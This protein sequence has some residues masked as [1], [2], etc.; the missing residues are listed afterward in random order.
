MTKRTHESTFSD[1]SLSV[2]SRETRGQR[3][4]KQKNEKKKYTDPFKCW[5]D[6]DFPQNHVTFKQ[7]RNC[8]ESGNPHS[9]GGSCYDFDEF[10]G[11]MTH[12]T[13][14][15]KALQKPY[16]EINTPESDV[17]YATFY[18]QH[19]FANIDILKKK[20]TESEKRILKR[21]N[22]NKVR[23]LKDILKEKEKKKRKEKRK[24]VRLPPKFSEWPN[25]FEYINEKD[26]TSTRNKKRKVLRECL[27]RRIDFMNDCVYDCGDISQ[28]WINAHLDFIIILQILA[29]QNNA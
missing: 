28:T 19:V 24:Q 27:N 8:P 7:E 1:N 9:V 29:A 5:N 12:P 14:R 6:T 11:E 16:Y 22:I 4:K 2:H 21:A 10:V 18:I 26:D 17:V 15:D 23:N 25:V 13:F 20:L 3:L